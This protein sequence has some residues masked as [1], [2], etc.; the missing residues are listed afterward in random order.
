MFKIFELIDVILTDSYRF[1]LGFRLSDWEIGQ[2]LYVEML[3]Y[4]R[5]S[6]LPRSDETS[7]RLKTSALRLFSWAH[8]LGF[9]HFIRGMRH[10]TIRYP[11]AISICHSAIAELSKGIPLEFDENQFLDHK[12]I[13]DRSSFVFKSLPKPKTSIKLEKTSS[14]SSFKN[15]N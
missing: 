15:F 13:I 6:K 12:Y 11:L 5:L 14:H 10:L 1:L 9:A 7:F 4:D 8:K 2:F 3:T